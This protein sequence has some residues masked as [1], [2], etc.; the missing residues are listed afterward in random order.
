VVTGIPGF[1]RDGEVIMR[2]FSA[3]IGLVVAF[4]FMMSAAVPDRAEADHWIGHKIV[5][6]IGEK[7]KD[8]GKSIKEIHKATNKKAAR[9]TKRRRKKIRKFLKRRARKDLRNVKRSGKKIRRKGKKAARKI[10]L[11][12]RNKSVRGKCLSQ[13]NRRR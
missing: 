9:K 5:K 11:K 6:K 12:L 10:C 13:V 8:A 4:M 2:R 7:A 3:S 1:F